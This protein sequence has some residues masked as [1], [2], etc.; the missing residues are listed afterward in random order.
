MT[1]D[2]P[3]PADL[4]FHADTRV[5][6]DP[7][8]IADDLPVLPPRGRGFTAR[9]VRGYL[10]VGPMPDWLWEHRGAARVVGCFFG[11]FLGYAGAFAVLIYLAGRGGPRVIHNDIAAILCLLIGCASVAVGLMPIATW[12]IRLGFRAPAV[13]G[14]SL[15]N[16]GVALLWFVIL[17]ESFRL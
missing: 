1:A 6:P 9:R 14:F 3:L 17:A 8:A 16:G 11:T 7:P 4:A 10:V 5:P 13:A 15:L 12:P 2:P